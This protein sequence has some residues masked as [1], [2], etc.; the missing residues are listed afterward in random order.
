M[1]A[2]PLSA[3]LAGANRKSAAIVRIAAAPGIISLTIKK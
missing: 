2:K 1:M 3:A